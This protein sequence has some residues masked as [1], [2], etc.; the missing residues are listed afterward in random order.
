MH[1][2]EMAEPSHPGRLHIMIQLRNEA[3]AT[4]QPQASSG[5]LPGTSD[6]P[7]SPSFTAHKAFQESVTITMGIMRPREEGIFLLLFL[8]ME[9]SKGSR[10]SVW[11][12]QEVNQVG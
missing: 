10:P 9:I 4:L 8:T 1:G 3:N 12:F 11:S 7:L 5:L 2:L 6:R